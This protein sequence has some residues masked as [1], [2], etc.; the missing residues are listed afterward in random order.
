MSFFDQPIPED[1][2]G[3]S[4]SVHFGASRQVGVNHTKLILQP[5]WHIHIMCF[6]LAIE[7]LKLAKLL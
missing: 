6:N 4:N 1:P 5:G 7:M 2:W 3:F